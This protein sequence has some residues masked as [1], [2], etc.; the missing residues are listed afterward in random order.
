MR[1]LPRR[2]AMACLAVAGLLVAYMAATV[3]TVARETV[4]TYPLKYPDSFDWLTNGLRYAGVPVECTW[5]SLLNPLV[6]AGLF[7]L[8]LDDAIIFLGPLYLL[9]TAAVI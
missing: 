1:R 2:E 3:A 6:Y 5:R 8:H 4:D 7:A 9:A